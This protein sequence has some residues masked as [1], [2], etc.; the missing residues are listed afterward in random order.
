MN[1]QIAYGEDVISR[2]GYCNEHE[3]GR[4]LLQARLVEALNTL[5]AQLCREA[6]AEPEQ[7]V[8][9]VV[10][11]N[12]AMHH[13]F[14]GLPVR[15]LV[16]APYVAAVSDPLGLRAKDLGLTLAPG[17]QVYLPPNIAG[18]VGT[19]HVAMALATGAWEEAERCVVALDIGTNTEV[20]LTRGGR[21]WCCSCASGPAFEGAH[22]QDGMRAAPGAIDSACRSS[23]GS[24][25]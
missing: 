24:R 13:I 10:V 22:I 20:T 18:F 6:A 7:I 14:A 11:G 9:A 4:A 3:G 19:D 8:D 1:P 12:T 23:R 2:I 5:A 17:A 21:S 25:T 15:Q 16:L